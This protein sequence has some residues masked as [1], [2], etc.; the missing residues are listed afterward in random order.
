MRSTRTH[1]RAL[2]FGGTLQRELCS[3]AA[4]WVMLASA[5][6]K[7]DRHDEP[8]DDAELS[9]PDPEL[10][11]TEAAA[12]PK[13]SATAAEPEV[14]DLAA[15][16]A[17]AQKELDRV[18]ALPP[19]P[20]APN[21]EK[22]RAQLV[23][24]AKTEPALFVR[25]PAPDPDE[26]AGTRSLR[27]NF[28]HTDFPWREL[29]K[30]RK[31]VFWNNPKLARQLL[32]K[33]GYLYSEKANHAFT[34]VSLIRP[35]HLFDEPEIWVQRGESVMHAR[36]EK[37]TKY[38]RYYFTDGPE[39]DKRVKL[40]HLD[41]VGTGAV[42][43]PLHRDFRSL[44]YRLF[45]E[46]AQIKHITEQYIIA[47]LRYGKYWIPTLLESDGAHL[48]RVAE[49]IDP[50][51]ANDLEQE[52]ARLEKLT[53]LVS[54]LRDAM[55]DQID[56]ALPF[57]EPKTEV[58]QQDGALR[59][60]WRYA[61]LAGRDTFRFNEDRYDVFDEHGR[62]IVPQV[63]I[64][65][66][67]DTFERAGGRWWRPKGDGKRELTAGR[68]DLSEFDREALRRTKYF[69]NFAR[70]H[71]QWF[72]VLTFPKYM[73]IELGYKERFF[74]WL[75]KKADHLRPG[76][77]I[78]IRGHTPWDD[79]EEHTHSFFI[80]E[81]DPLTGVPIAIAG[82]AGPANLWSWE[83]EARRTPNRTIRTRIRPKV[84]WLETFLVV[85][86]EELSPPALVSGKR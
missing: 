28:E 34:L 68:L 11:A 54:Q 37:R 86:K 1:T 56:E 71:D 84:E 9:A 33:E 6:S 29:K 46:R 39:K 40:L 49:V 43:K 47:D 64:D 69:L 42:P 76:D 31:G 14:P 85:G 4:L 2:H 62:P 41:R 61:Y 78:L 60:Q 55:R 3:L 36:K 5:C 13:P 12:L 66:M 19:L 65:F 21:F 58:G 59:R 80:Y 57:D 63:C 73:R 75:S 23:A 8:H 24:R 82:N 67:S 35:D 17:A 74:K 51:I 32:L 83:T 10:T 22:N 72:D 53:R 20:G 18:L 70:E 79:V 45:F 26:K 52:R 44:R 50:K 15:R 16:N 81:T 25:A 7:P 27:L 77:I 38:E 48:K 30:L